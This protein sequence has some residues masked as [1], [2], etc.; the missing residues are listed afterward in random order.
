M[1]RHI[2]YLTAGFL[3]ALGGWAWADYNFTEGSGKVAFAFTCFT[4]KVC[5][6][7]TLVNSAGAEAGVAALPLQVSVANTAANGT[8]M[9]MTGTGGTFPSTQS[10]TWTVQPGNTPNTTP[11]LQI[12]RD[13]AGNSRGANVNASNQL[14]VSC[15]NG[16]SASSSITGW[17]GGTL[18][19]MANYGTSPGA[20]LVPGVNANVTASALPSGAATS[21]NQSTMISSLST[22]ATNTGAAIPAGTANIGNV[23]QIS[24]YPTSAVPIT[25][26]GTGTTTTASATL[27]ASAGGL[28]TYMC[29]L[30]VRSNATAAAQGHITMTGLTTNFAYAH[31][32]APVASGIGITEMIYSPC[33]KSSATNTAIVVTSPT[34]GAGGD[35]TVNLSGYQGN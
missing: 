27:A 26:S 22:I 9:L 31:W 1:K 11:W 6:T 29:S 3:I 35:V 32:T 13:A 4:T 18:G 16:C 30:S 14:S 34:I 7:A 19:A 12:I 23:G 17:A 21:S 33:V 10:G 15:D 24:A 8:A 25:A 2:A 20:V 5:G 28:F